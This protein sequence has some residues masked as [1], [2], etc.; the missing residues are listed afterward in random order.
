M[1]VR[2]MYYI[3]LGNE[4]NANELANEMG[5]ESATTMAR[6]RSLRDGC[7]G[8]LLLPTFPAF[9]REGSLGL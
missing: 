4:G 7:Y 2:L 6:F 1:N 8:F 3:G 5:W 9:F